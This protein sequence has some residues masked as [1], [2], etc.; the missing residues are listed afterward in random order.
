MRNKKADAFKGG[1]LLAEIREH[2]AKSISLYK[3]LLKSG[4]SE[5][6][7]KVMLTTAL[8]QFVEDSRKK[9]V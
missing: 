8:D 4:Q 1:L 7:A 5:S 2:S 6:E 9:D 3:Q